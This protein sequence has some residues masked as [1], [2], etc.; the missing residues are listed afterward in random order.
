MLMRFHLMEQPRKTITND[1]FILLRYRTKMSKYHQGKYFGENSRDAT[2]FVLNLN[3]V[4]FLH[5]R[6]FEILL[7][8]IVHVL[9]IPGGVV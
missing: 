4:K 1:N 7:I 5:A 9:G 8:K 3:I 6:R 2:F